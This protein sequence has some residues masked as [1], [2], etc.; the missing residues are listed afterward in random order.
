MLLLSPVPSHFQEKGKAFLSRLGTIDFDNKQEREE[1]RRQE[2]AKHRKQVATLGLEQK[3]A[4]YRAMR[5]ES[6]WITGGGG[7]GKTK[8]IHLIEEGLKL[9]GKQV[10]L[11]APTGVAAKAVRGQT[12]HHLLKIPVEFSEKNTDQLKKLLKDNLYLNQKMANSVDVL[13]IDEISMIPGWLFEYCS[14][15][16]QSA[17]YF[18]YNQ[19]LPFGGIQVLVSGDFFQLPP[20][21]VVNKDNPS[22]SSLF[23]FQTQVWKTLFPAKQ[24][25]ELLQNFRQKSDP[26][27][28]T[29]LDH[30]RVG[31]VPDA[32]M[33]KL[34]MKCASSRAQLARAAVPSTPTT[35]AWK[36]KEK[37]D[38]FQNPTLDLLLAN[39]EKARP[40]P[41]PRTSAEETLFRFRLFP[42]NAQ[43]Q[44]YN[45]LREKSLQKFNE[46][47]PTAYP[48]R[49]R[50]EAY[51]VEQLNF[52][53]F[54]ASQIDRIQKGTLQVSDIKYQTMLKQHTQRKRSRTLVFDKL[55]RS[56]FKISGY[57]PKTNHGI[58][59]FQLNVGSRVMLT[60]N[61]IKNGLVNSS[62]GY[63]C[64]C[65]PTGPVVLFD[66]KPEPQTILPRIIRHACQDGEW[67]VEKY[68][69][70]VAWSSTIHKTQSLSLHLVE[71]DLGFIFAHGQAYV[72]LSR[73]TSWQGLRISALHPKFYSVTDSSVIKFYQSMF[74][75]NLLYRK[76]EE[77]SKARLSKENR[78]LDE[79][80]YANLLKWSSAAHHPPPPPPPLPPTPPREEK[81]I[82]PSSSQSCAQKTTDVAIPASSSSS[83]SAI[84]SDSFLDQLIAQSIPQEMLD[85]VKYRLS[86][87]IVL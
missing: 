54:Q 57:D 41:P 59:P 71:V 30:I 81:K 25:I 7:R 26:D 72:A 34:E 6:L 33:Q 76:E 78:A 20:V 64:R 10:V 48:G 80:L 63:V 32:M 15:V 51:T 17:N 19:K 73:V 36:E 58:L 13:I 50:F 1:K 44:R 8:L 37:G 45:D 67:I 87:F 83:S 22:T 86:K 53:K 31:H 18:N 46:T 35:S 5:G 62:C 70:T 42:T 23:C 4:Y 55:I 79:K 74:P 75:N 39:D 28:T 2:I 85:I 77:K 66:D 69:L 52:H 12:L 60:T 27:F 61:D 14:A 9:Q 21:V 3:Q 84:H 82:S 16:F 40:P 68:P 38:I 29:L 65:E 56:Q 49:V 11:G 43:S 24:C 47:Q